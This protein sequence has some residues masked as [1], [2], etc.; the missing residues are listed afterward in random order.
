LRI[1]QSDRHQV[2]SDVGLLSAVEEGAC[3]DRP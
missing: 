3:S 1:G 2:C